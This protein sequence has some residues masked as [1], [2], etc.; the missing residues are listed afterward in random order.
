MKSKTTN[1]LWKKKRGLA[2]SPTF[3]KQIAIDVC[4]KLN[5]GELSF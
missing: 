4:E 3:P 2:N 5:S 1:G